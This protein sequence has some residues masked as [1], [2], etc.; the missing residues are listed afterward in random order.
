MLLD[1]T[2]HAEMIAL[3]SAFEAL[4]SKQLKDC[5]MYVTLEPCSMCAGALVLSRLENLYFGAYDNKTGACGSVLN[6]TNNK[7][8][9]H[10]INVY[11]GILDAECSSLLKA[12]FNLKRNSSGDVIGNKNNFS[13]N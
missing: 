12:F 5:S 1:S 8:L 10:K 13:V 7:H 4:N 3:T 2:A 6:I 9:N 11:G